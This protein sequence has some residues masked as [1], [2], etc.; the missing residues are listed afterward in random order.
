MI[1]RTG[2]GSDS[3]EFLDGSLNTKQSES[4]MRG[5]VVDGT[6]SSKVRFSLTHFIILHINGG[7]TANTLI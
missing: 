4:V 1:G 2:N 6:L 7:M 5:L 3:E